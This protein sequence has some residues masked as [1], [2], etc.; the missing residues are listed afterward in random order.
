MTTMEDVKRGVKTSRQLLPH[1]LMVRPND[2]ISLLCNSIHIFN[3]ILALLQWR[4]YT[5][6]TISHFV[7]MLS[8]I[9]ST[10]QLWNSMWQFSTSTLS[11]LKLY[12]SNYTI[13]GPK[14]Q[15]PQIHLFPI[16]I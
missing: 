15:G 6:R 11:Y 7:A 9:N 12:E 5:T 14:S 3:I 1:I 10:K 4:K 13:L 2:I 16:E 8:Y